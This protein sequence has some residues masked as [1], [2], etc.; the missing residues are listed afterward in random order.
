MTSRPLATVASALVALASVG[1]CQAK[2]DGTVALSTGAQTRSPRRDEPPVALNA[3]S[4]VHYPEALASQRLGGTVI[5]RLFVDSTGRIVADS[6][7]VQESSG[8]PAL[9]SAAL[10]GALQLR[11][12][13]ALRDGI[14]VAAQF[15]QPVDF[16]ASA[17]GA[18]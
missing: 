5:L 7:A 11:Y 10:R 6:S 14:P 15:L 13:P 16:R 1:G 17:D 3:N 2:P 8:Y 12:A 4:P 9:D 18:K